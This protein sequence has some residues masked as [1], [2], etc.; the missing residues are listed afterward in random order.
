MNVFTVKHLYVT[1]AYNDCAL[2][3]DRHT[4][5]KKVKLPKQA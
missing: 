3:Q 2:L 1:I 5:D 4:Q